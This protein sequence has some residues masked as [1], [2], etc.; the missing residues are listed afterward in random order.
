[1]MS[2]KRN[3]LFGKSSYNLGSLKWVKHRKHLIK[4][5]FGG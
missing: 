3:L 5:M 1:L 2:R 4:P